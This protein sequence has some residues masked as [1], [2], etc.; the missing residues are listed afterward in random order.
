LPRPCTHIDNVGKRDVHSYKALGAKK[1]IIRK[2]HQQYHKQRQT[3]LSGGSSRAS[4][5]QQAE[6]CT[7]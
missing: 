3:L 5:I 6:P 4:D 7:F 1:K 2:R